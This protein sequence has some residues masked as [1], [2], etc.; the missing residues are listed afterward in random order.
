M[1]IGPTLTLH[2]IFGFV[3]GSEYGVVWDLEDGGEYMYV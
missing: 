1:I 2:S 3:K